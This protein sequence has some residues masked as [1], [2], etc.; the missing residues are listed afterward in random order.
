MHTIIFA[1]LPTW[2]FFSL[3]YYWKEE[4]RSR[5]AEKIID[6]AI[7]LPLMAAMGAILAIAFPIALLWK[8]FRNA[9]RG[10]SLRTWEK[11]GIRYFL[12]FGNFRLVYDEKARKPY[13]R[14]FLV[15]IVR[16][17]TKIKH[18]PAK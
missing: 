12:A 4:T 16:P 13:N 6:L 8:F 18:S 1:V 9:I 5:K 17:A 11:A 14:F 7:K 10:V 3:L 2:F 15:R